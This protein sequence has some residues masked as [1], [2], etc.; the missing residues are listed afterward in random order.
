M[1]N[2]ET[3]PYPLAFPLRPQP[4]QNASS[5]SVRLVTRARAME[6]MQKEALVD[7]A[8]GGRGW[9]LVCDEGPY[10]NGTDLAPF[11]L[12]YFTAGL[13]NAYLGEIVAAAETSGVEL[14]ELEL[15]QDSFYTMEGSAMRGD[16][17]GG[18]LPVRL[19]VRADSDPGDPLVRK[20]VMQAVTRSPADALL[21]MALSS[22]F[23]IEHDGSPVT[24]AEA[25]E[26]RDYPS[27]ALSDAAFDAASP[28]GG[29]DY[30]HDI[31]TKLEGA[32]S[33][34]DREGGAGSSLRAEQKRTLHI[35]GIARLRDDGLSKTRIQLYKPIGSHF[36]F[37]CDVRDSGGGERAPSPL[38]YLS[39]GIAFC[40]LTQIG[41]YVTIVK[42][43]LSRYALLQRTEFTRADEHGQASAEPVKTLV[44][45]SGGPDEDGVRR[46]VD[47][48]ERTCFLHAA[49]RTP[50][51][52]HVRVTDL[53]EPA[54]EPAAAGTS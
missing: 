54:E 50:L 35:R 51:K 14:P 38:V 41:R 3:S 53:G 43:P 9:R 33:V 45:L 49:A 27:V 30:P 36:A 23:A 17:R 42:Q 47:M 44:S 24:P 29:A 25:R 7:C 10:L 16:M 22:Q 18:A 52:T 15:I 28:L 12:A 40:Y 5:G 32:E 21:R 46:I 34:F 2:I 48:G 4:E 1:A 31:V 37:L 13:I 26:W 8:P 39:A 19:H 20:L 6:G 11:P